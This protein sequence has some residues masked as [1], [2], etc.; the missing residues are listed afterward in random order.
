MYTKI[1]SWVCIKSGGLLKKE[2]LLVKYHFE[3]QLP[4]DPKP[5]IT[6]LEFK[7][8]R[9]K[10]LRFHLFELNAAEFCNY[11]FFFPGLFKKSW[12]YV[13]KLFIFYFSNIFCH[14][15]NHV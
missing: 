12:F 15:Q 9:T 3:Y 1:L 10:K 8:S 2:S 5:F 7:I 4:A 11:A 14:K 13:Y 6:F